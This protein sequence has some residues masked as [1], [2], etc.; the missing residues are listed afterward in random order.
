MSEV[1]GQN[2]EKT[3]YELLTQAMD[4][5]DYPLDPT[6]IRHRWIDSTRYLFT[7]HGI[8]GNN[9][10]GDSFFGLYQNFFQN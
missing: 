3:K 5:S 6:F 1:G 4:T 8:H 10:R 2:G 7:C 9:N